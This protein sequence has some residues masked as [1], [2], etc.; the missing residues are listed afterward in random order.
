MDHLDITEDEWLA[1]IADVI[2]ENS[3]PPP[4]EGW[5]NARQIWEYMQER[6]DDVPVLGTFT[7]QLNRQAEKGILERKLFGKLAYYRK[8]QNG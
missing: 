4:E 3:P 6:G 8:V 1:A 2:Q 5:R 7:S